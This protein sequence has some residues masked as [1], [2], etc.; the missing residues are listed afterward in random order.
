M[1]DN[2][3]VMLFKAIITFM[4][5][6]NETFGTVSTPL[7][8]YFKNLEQVRFT[9][10]GKIEFHNNLIRAYCN[11]NETGIVTRDFSAFKSTRL[12]QTDR[13][14]VDFEYIF[15]VATEEQKGYIWAHFLTL[16][17][18]VRPQSEAKTTLQELSL[19]L[20]QAVDTSQG[21]D[22]FTNIVK[23]IEKEVTHMDTDN[24]I[25]LVSKIMQSGTFSEIVADLTAGVESGQIDLSQLLHSVKQP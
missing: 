18:I 13:A 20:P 6:L 1:T 4:S 11:E 16:L 3:S 15:R 9:E 5:D 8:L 14:F 24:P 12:Q 10:P 22:L 2:T 21:A 19:T 7:H 17:A 23:K 25:D